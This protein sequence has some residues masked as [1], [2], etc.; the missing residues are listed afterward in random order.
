MR[1]DGKVLFPKQQVME[2]NRKLSDPCQLIKSNYEEY[3][4]AY[5]IRFN[6]DGRKK[7]GTN[8]HE[9]A[10]F[11]AL[12]GKYAWDVARKFLGCDQPVKNKYYFVITAY[13]NFAEIERK[14]YDLAPMEP[15]VLARM[16][17]ETK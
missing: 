11:I 10:G 4:R 5:E 6:A 15:Y 13:D 7:D 9:S 3:A 1:I 2:L 17:V 14:Y 8:W 12:G 16:I